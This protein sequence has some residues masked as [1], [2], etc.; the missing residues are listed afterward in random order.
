MILFRDDAVLKQAYMQSG[1]PLN[2]ARRSG[3]LQDRMHRQVDGDDH[4]QITSVEGNS[5]LHGTAPQSL[6]VLRPEPEVN[7]MQFITVIWF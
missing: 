1:A 3:R 7:I 6:P 4:R 2:K 5:E